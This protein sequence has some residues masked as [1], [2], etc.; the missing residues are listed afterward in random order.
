ML[1]IHAL[2]NRS[3]RGELLR[4]SKICGLIV[5]CIVLVILVLLLAG[6]SF[7]ILWCFGNL[8][9]TLLPGQ[10]SVCPS[11]LLWNPPWR[12]IGTVI[13]SNT[14]R[15]HIRFHPCYCAPSRLHYVGAVG[16][17]HPGWLVSGFM[18]LSL[19]LNIYRDTGHPAWSP[20]VCIICRSLRLTN[21]SLEAILFLFIIWYLI[22]LVLASRERIGI[23]RRNQPRTNV[24]RRIPLLFSS[25][26]HGGTLHYFTSVP[27]LVLVYWLIIFIR[28]MGQFLSSIRFADL[29]GCSC[30]NIFLGHK[31]LCD[32]FS[33][34]VRSPVSRGGWHI[35]HESADLT[36]QL[37]DSLVFI[38]RKR[39]NFCI[40]IW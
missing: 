26:F 27:S 1:R 15:S 6:A 25:F 4:G 30:H 33:G 16:P 39:L 7:G 37:D 2:Y 20:S 14:K 11:L 34:D 23:F 22:C 10:F 9:C 3:H 29:M 21:R 18:L 5:Y 28:L 32:T 24:K 13:R 40:V 38:C 19:S 8:L 35:Y 36:L 17:R 12:I 31:F